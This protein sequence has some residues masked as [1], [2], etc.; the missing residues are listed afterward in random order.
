[1]MSL[2]DST[3]TITFNQGNVFSRYLNVPHESKVKQ[4][5][6]YTAA[7]SEETSSI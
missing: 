7:P 2:T 6:K 5:I 1:M 3:F 4:K